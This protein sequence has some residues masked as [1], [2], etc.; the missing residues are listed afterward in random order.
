[1]V[2]Q[3]KVLMKTMPIISANGLF[4]I[5][6]L[7]AYYNSLIKGVATVMISYS[8][9]NGIKMHSN[10][11]LITGFLKN[12]LKFRGFV[13]S[14]WQGIDRIT[15]EHANYT[16]SIETGVNV[17]IDMIMVPYNYTEFIDGITFLVKGKFISMTRIDD[18]VRRILRVKF[19]MGL[20]E[21]PLADYSMT[22]YLGR[23]VS[24][25]L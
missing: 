24:P 23:K 9:Y 17:G 25:Y 11:Q 7:A 12:R 10:R 4:S 8:S 2:E 16:W 19:G 13:I 15:A 22:K 20:F 3:T 6:M 21:N 18:A 14:D 1:M 5:H